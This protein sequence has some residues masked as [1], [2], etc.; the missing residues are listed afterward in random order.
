MVEE[1]LNQN[2]KTLKESNFVLYTLAPIQSRF[3]DNDDMNMTQH[4]LLDNF[5]NLQIMWDI[6][7][8][9]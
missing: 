2:Y 3:I 1:N 5:K 6:I 9:V 4:M 8:N 7:C